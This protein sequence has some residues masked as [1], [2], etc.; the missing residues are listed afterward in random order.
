MFSGGCR[1]NSLKAVKSLIGKILFA[2]GS[3]LFEM[4]TTMLFVWRF[5]L[6]HPLTAVVGP[7]RQFTTLQRRGS[8]WG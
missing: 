7:F 3:W 2:S 4:A 8:D 5:G 6:L 1:D